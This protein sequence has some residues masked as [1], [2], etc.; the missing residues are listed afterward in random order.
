MTSKQLANVSNDHT[1][2]VQ[3]CFTLKMKKLCYFET[4]VTILPVNMAQD[5]QNA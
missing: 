3:E 5:T 1:A 4:P 2:F